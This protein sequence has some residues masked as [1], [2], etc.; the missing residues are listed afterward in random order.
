MLV[1]APAAAQELGPKDGRDLPPT[2]TG[3]VA[4]GAAAPD[5]TL[6]ALDGRRITLSEYRGRMDV[7]L[8]FYRGHW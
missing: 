3:R 4:L 5:F 2:D 6:Q 7:V 1:G 8:V